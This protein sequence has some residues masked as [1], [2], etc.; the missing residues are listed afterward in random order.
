MVKNTRLNELI[1]L[2]ASFLALGLLVDVAVDVEVVFVVVF[3]VFV[4]I[5][6]HGATPG[7]LGFRPTT[8]QS[9]TARAVKAMRSC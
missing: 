7:F 2:E 8:E 5:E 3:E 1:L 9:A 4:G 6:T